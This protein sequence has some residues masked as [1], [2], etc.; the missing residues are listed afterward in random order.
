MRR[1]LTAVAAGI[2]A[3]AGAVYVLGYGQGRATAPDHVPDWVVNR[4][5]D[6]QARIAARRADLQQVL[7]DA[8][9]LPEGATVEWGAAQPITAEVLAEV[10]AAL[11]AEGLEVH[12]I[13]MPEGWPLT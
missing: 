12:V 9:V 5:E 8:G 4:D 7:T 6:R 2:G 13:P 3:V 10:R 1:A 11:E